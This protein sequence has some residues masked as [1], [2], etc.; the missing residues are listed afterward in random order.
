MATNA[1]FM[2]PVWNSE[3]GVEIYDELSKVMLPKNSVY[4]AALLGLVRL[5]VYLP[6][7]ILK[8]VISPLSEIP[9]LINDE[10]RLIKIVAELRLE[11]GL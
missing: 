7:E 9:L 3:T 8:T 11:K 6:D 4:D 2:S 10:Y 5:L 1:M